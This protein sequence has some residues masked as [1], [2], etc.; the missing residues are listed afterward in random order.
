VAWHESIFVG[1]RADEG[2]RRRSKLKSQGNL[3]PTKFQPYDDAPPRRYCGIFAIFVAMRRASSRVSRL[4]A[5][6]RPGSSSKI[7]VGQRLPVLVL[8]MKQASV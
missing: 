5:V 3:K 4:A 6:R 2:R 7:D 1:A 8:Y